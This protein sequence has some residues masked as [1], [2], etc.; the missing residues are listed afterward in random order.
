M[1]NSERRVNT[2]EKTVREHISC[3]LSVAKF[4][5]K[6]LQLDRIFANS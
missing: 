1:C 2:F 5:E 4:I 6:A 3:Q